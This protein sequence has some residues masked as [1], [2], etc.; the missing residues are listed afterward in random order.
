MTKQN[1]EDIL[2]K[3]RILDPLAIVISSEI[4]ALESMTEEEIKAQKVAELEAQKAEYQAKIQA[5]EAEKAT[6]TKVDV[7]EEPIEIIK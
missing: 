2:K 1:I 5:I 6:L 3:Y 4:I 7:I